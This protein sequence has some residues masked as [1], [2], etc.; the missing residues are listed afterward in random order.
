MGPSLAP[1]CSSSFLPFDFTHPPTPPP[2][3]PL[4]P[5]FFRIH[6]FYDSVL[7]W[8]NLL[9]PLMTSPSRPQHPHAS[10][11]YA[12]TLAAGALART[13]SETSEAGLARAVKDAR[14]AVDI[15]PKSARNIAIYF[16]CGVRGEKGG[17]VECDGK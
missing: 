9:I 1:D 16:Q 7:S 8:V 2:P 10:K 3:S 17:V 5:S 4:K 12:D 13:M 11:S 14:A 15:Y 6:N